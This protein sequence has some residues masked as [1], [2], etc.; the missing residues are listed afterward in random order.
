MMQLR[1]G[2]DMEYKMNC[3]KALYEIEFPRFILQ[4]LIENCFVHGS[5]QEE[6]RTIE[7]VIKCSDCMD[8]KVINSGVFLN[9]E[10]LNQIRNKMRSPLTS[11]HI[12]LA[13][14]SKRLE[15]LYGDQ[16]DISVETDLETGLIV[17]IRFRK[18]VE[19]LN[20]E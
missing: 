5:S 11:D 4:P 8:V 6:V 19:V 20:K 3:E 12:G 9:E 1:Y 15:L 14:V 16:G 18:Y 7:V 17:H 13:N 10:E 2:H